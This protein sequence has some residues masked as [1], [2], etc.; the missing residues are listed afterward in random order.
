MQRGVVAVSQCQKPRGSRPCLP[1]CRSASFESLGVSAKRLR[2]LDAKGI[3]EAFPIQEQTFAD[4]RAGNDMI[5]R[6]HTGTGKTLAFALPIAEKLAE[7][8]TGRRAKPRALVL[9]PTRELAIQVASEFETVASD[10]RVL[11]VYGGSSIGPQ[12]T[13]QIFF[14][15]L[16]HVLFSLSFS[17]SLAAFT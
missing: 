2:Q 13:D 17:L 6:A 5:G 3:T 4:I 8:A 11:S 16:I 1:Q 7:T 9:V 14:S 10:L 12:R 15:A